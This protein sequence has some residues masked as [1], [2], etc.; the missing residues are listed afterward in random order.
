MNTN[1]KFNE[2][3]IDLYNNPEKIEEKKKKKIEYEKKE[4][5]NE[6]NNITLKNILKLQNCIQQNLFEKIDRT[7]SYDKTFIC[8]NFESY[9]NAKTT[10]DMSNIDDKNAIKDMEIFKEIIVPELKKI[11]V[12]YTDKINNIVT[13][14]PEKN[15][16][17]YREYQFFSDSIPKNTFTTFSGAIIIRVSNILSENNTSKK[18]LK[19]E[20]S[21]NHICN[22][23][24]FN[25]W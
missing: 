6:N 15:K 20:G 13:I 21:I 22:H 19:F 12:N 18:I 16:D 24:K 17:Y 5:Q 2:D 3:F 1:F 25:L 9:Y 10:T 7:K 4:I 8:K 11:N 23:N 14:I